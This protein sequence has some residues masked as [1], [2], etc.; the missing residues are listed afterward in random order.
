MTGGKV[1]NGRQFGGIHY[2]GTEYTQ[3]ADGTPVPDVEEGG[4]LHGN[5]EETKD[6]QMSFREILPQDRYRI[7]ELFEEWF[8]VEYKDDFYDNL[9]DHGSM[10]SQ[11][12]YTLVATTAM[13][14][15]PQ[16]E[17]IVACL[18]GCKL[19]SQKLNEASRKLLIPGY[20]PC[21]VDPKPQTTMDNDDGDINMDDF[22]NDKDTSAQNDDDEDDEEAECLPQVFYIMTLGVVEEYRKRGL[23]SYLVERALEDQLVI[24]SDGDDNDEWESPAAS[25]ATV[26]KELPAAAIANTTT[27]FRQ[28]KQPR[29]APCET[30]YLHV[31]ITNAAAIRFYE[32][33]GFERLREITN[34]YTIEDRKFNCYLYAKF[35]SKVQKRQAISSLVWGQLSVWMRSIWTTLVSSYNY[36]AVN[37]HESGKDD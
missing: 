17:Q 31:I 14:E 20:Q 6:R 23:A 11:K 32:K 30:A 21:D 12:L 15:D 7:Q 34:Y 5:R 16:Q 28:K 36:W 37:E 9:C 18:L 29:S 22:E 24:V 35:F 27:T 33:L 8:P 13:E 10:G 1:E 2:D 19:G 4:F 25:T 26:D 3:S